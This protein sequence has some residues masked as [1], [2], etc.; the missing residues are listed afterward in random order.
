MQQMKSRLPHVII[1]GDPKIQRAVISKDVK[2]EKYS[3][4]IEGYGLS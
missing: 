4:A 1:K 3:L 2:E